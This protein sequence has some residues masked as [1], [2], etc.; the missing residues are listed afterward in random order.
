M[1]ASTDNFKPESIDLYKPGTIEVKRDDE[2]KNVTIE[3]ASTVVSR[4]GPP[5]LTVPSVSSISESP[6]ARLL[7]NAAHSQGRVKY[8]LAQKPRP[9]MWIACCYMTKKLGYVACSPR[10][11]IEF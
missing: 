5:P 1:R 4:A 2:K 9:G 7:T 3:R 11:P 6:V 8:L 10:V